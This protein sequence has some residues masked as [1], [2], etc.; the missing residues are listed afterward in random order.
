MK[1]LMIGFVL[2]FAVLVPNG[3][4]RACRFPQSHKKRNN[5]APIEFWGRHVLH[6]NPLKPC[7][8]P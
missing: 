8:F 5:R 4:T 7:P 1:A 6:L 3:C 2:S